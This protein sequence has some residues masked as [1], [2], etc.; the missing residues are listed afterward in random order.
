MIKQ[1]PSSTRV[2]VADLETKP[3]T[4]DRDEFI[5]RAK[6]NKYHDYLSDDAMNSITLVR[7]LVR[8][9]YED[10]AEN[11]KQGKYDATK[12][13]S[14]EWAKSPEGRETFATIEL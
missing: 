4:F 10:L 7:H 9:G 5:R 6:R 11:A 8:A 1:L 2:L 3:K 14:D 12:E 13:E